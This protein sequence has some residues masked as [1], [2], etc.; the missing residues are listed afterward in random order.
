MNLW[1]HRG[2]R[3]ATCTRLI[4][5]AHW[6][7]VRRPL[8]TAALPILPVTGCAAGTVALSGLLTAARRPRWTADEVTAY[9]WILPSQRKM[10]KVW[11]E[12]TFRLP[13]FMIP[14]PAALSVFSHG[15]WKHRPTSTN[16]QPSRRRVMTAWRRGFAYWHDGAPGNAPRTMTSAAQLL[17][18]AES[19][20]R[21]RRQ[22]RAEHRA[23]WKDGSVHWMEGTNM[24]VGTTPEEIRASSSGP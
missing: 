11:V 2:Q 3:W 18:H 24:V 7:T 8:K 9:I 6:L 23:R 1:R 21:G 19:R 20:S 12:Q 16:R 15:R 22:T 10:P 17:R 14:C 5:R 13:A 4:C